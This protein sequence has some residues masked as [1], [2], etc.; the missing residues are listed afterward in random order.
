MNLFPDSIK[1]IK[2][3]E[4]LSSKFVI[5]FLILLLEHP[6][7]RQLS[8]EKFSSDV[9]KYTNTF[10][11]FTMQNSILKILLLFLNFIG[12]FIDYS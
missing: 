4:L 6:Q 5:F 12:F 10:A 2:K 11:L 9:N 7:F 1:K 3:K 8:L